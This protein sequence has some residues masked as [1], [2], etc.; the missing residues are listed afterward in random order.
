LKR[1][2]FIREAPYI[3]LFCCTPVAMGENKVKSSTKKDK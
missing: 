3:L 1:L 2:V